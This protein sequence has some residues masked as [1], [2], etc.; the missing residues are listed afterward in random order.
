VKNEK[1]YIYPWLKSF[2]LSK[3]I[4]ND[5]ES[6]T[7]VELVLKDALKDLSHAM[8]RK[9]A[10]KALSYAQQIIK[11]APNCLPAYTTLYQI[12]TFQQQ[13]ST[14]EQASLGAIKHN[15]LHSL[16]YHALSNACRFQ[17]KTNQALQAMEKAV[18]LEPENTSWLNSLAIMH[19]ELGHFK[20]ALKLF[21]QCIEQSPNFTR[22]Y[23]NRSD[24]KAQLPNKNIEY[25]IK[26]LSIE[27]ADTISK[28]YAAY[29]LFKHYEVIEDFNKAFHYLKLGATKQ[30]VSFNYDH[31]IEL[32]EHRNIEKVFSKSFFNENKTSLNKTD[33][34]SDSPIFICGLPRSGTTL[35][36][37]II[38]SH[39]EVAAGDELFE[40]AQATQNVLQ[41][42]KPKQV[43]PFLANEL[44]T[45]HW[46]NI[47]ERYLALTQHVN[48]KRYFTDKMPLN[49]KAIGLI[50]MALPEAK[51]VYC[52]RPPMD[53]LLGA[54]KQILDQG[55]KYTYDL[56]EL[57]SMIIAHHHLMQHWLNVLPNKIFTLSYQ[58]L[59]NN[60]KETTEKLLQ[61]LG[62]E[63]Q[64]PCFNF[65]ENNRVIHTMSNAQV[66]KPLFRS[67]INA[68]HKYHAQL[69]P[70]ADKFEKA[71]LKV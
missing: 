38:S 13:F 28:V 58:N 30:R 24:L 62:L 23:W 6:N 61:F 42:V 49:Y 44:T 69:K 22:A 14:L 11:Q 56:D 54:Y 52:Q 21:D 63:W 2:I 53:L 39:S 9:Q 51:I 68:W 55:N 57:T 3:I 5:R 70:Y 45:E 16:S 40:L 17:R 15:P 43:F 27:T 4:I 20:T 33:I 59:I 66:R 65:H 34:P 35:T 10:D 47:G 46:Q 71:G 25:L 48:T 50:N 12:L 60:Q 18:E 64:I 36:E 8:H 19:K 31:K 37:Q 7:T 1:F 26:L 32:N 67:S 29:T 41:E